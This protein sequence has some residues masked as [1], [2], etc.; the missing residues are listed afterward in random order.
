[1]F[2]GS[3]AHGNGGVILK[4][5]SPARDELFSSLAPPY[6]ERAR[7]RGSK[8]KTINESFLFSFGP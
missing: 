8:L 7:V 1:M 6:G 2:K 4:S 3:A 5:S